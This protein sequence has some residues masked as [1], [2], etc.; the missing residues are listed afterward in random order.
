MKPLRVLSYAR[1]Q[2]PR[3][4][5]ELKEFVRFPSVSNQPRHAHDLRRCA[6]WLATHLRRIGLEQIRIVPTKRHPIVYAAWLHARGRPTI[7][8][9]GHYDVQPAE[10]LQ[11][12]RTPPFEPVVKDNNLYGRGACDDKG[13]LFTHVK[14]LESYLR[15]ERKLPV[16]VKC[17][18]EGGE[19]LG[20]S[21]GLEPFIRRNQSALHADA[22][23]MS[24]TRMLGPGRP[25]LG[26]S[27]RGNLRL[28]LEV[29]GPKQDLHSGN[30][31]GAVHNPLQALCEI[32][33][34]LHDAEGRVTVPGF[35][36]KVREWSAEEREYMERTGPKDS[37]ILRD[38]GVAQA[39]G[40][41]GYS[42]YERVTIRPA[43]TLNGIS[44]GYQGAGIKTVIPARALG[45]ISLRLVPDQDPP[46]I[47]QLLHEHIE[48]VAPATVS[49]RV[50]TLGASN[51]ALV[52]R[53]YP[54]LRAAAFAYEKGFGA[55]PVFLRSGGSVPAAS[56]FQKTLG[57]PTVLMGF[58]LPDDH[59]HAPNEKFHL[60]NFY[61]GI[62]T[63]IWYLAAAAKLA[64]KRK[65][66]RNQPA[67]SGM[68]QGISKGAAKS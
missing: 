5:A 4:V 36:E 7:L 19:E 9:Y 41:P 31:G 48:R 33:A 37:E 45:K 21:P 35:Y 17:I 11:E 51:P 15:A 20:N 58:A 23:L 2:R 46:E 56:I 65:D 38:A 68:Q 66:M 57:I 63:S 12:W 22:V 10:P 64:A 44:G 1:R 26:Y 3:F 16:N 39:W 43:L 28:E 14:A 29:Y 6:S 50:R 27:Q 13:Q 42:L 34:S 52:N 18:F 53:N 61:R 49:V 32:I 47:A 25:A 8:I 40:E 67:Q 54:A 60:P 30:F 59:V 24:D 62:E 55:R